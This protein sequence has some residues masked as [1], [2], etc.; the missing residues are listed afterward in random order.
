LRPAGITSSSQQGK[1]KATTSDMSL[2]VSQSRV[3]NKIRV[4]RDAFS[5][6]FDFYVQHSE[7]LHRAKFQFHKYDV[8][9]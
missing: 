4:L 6:A 2:I 8:T 3:V 7:V 5:L 1:M 9:L